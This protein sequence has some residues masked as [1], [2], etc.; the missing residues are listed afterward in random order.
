MLVSLAPAAGCARSAGGAKLETAATVT[1]EAARP[2]VA[3]TCPRVERAGTISTGYAGWARDIPPEDM[4]LALDVLIPIQERLGSL[5]CA[6]VVA[7]CRPNALLAVEL[8]DNRPSAAK[9]RVLGVA[10]AAERQLE[11]RLT[12]S[13]EEQWQADEASLAAYLKACRTAGGDPAAGEDG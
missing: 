6:R 2:P 11:L 10:H 1:A 8:E 7:D 4:V 3:P 5:F 12:Y 13:E 9:V